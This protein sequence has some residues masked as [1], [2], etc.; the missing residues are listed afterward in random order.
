M[1][2]MQPTYVAS[3]YATPCH[4][5]DC[6]S[7]NRMIVSRGSQGALKILTERLQSGCARFESGTRWLAEARVTWMRPVI[8]SISVI[9]AIA[10]PDTS[11]TTVRVLMSECIAVKVLTHPFDEFRHEGAC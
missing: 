10:A 1:V 9:E 8:L 4:D 2:R 5:I 7:Y 3:T 6:S 11:R